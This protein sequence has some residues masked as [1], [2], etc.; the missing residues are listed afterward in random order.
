LV[1]GTSR[2]WAAA[3]RASRRPRRRRSRRSPITTRPP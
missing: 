1:F 2:S 3:A